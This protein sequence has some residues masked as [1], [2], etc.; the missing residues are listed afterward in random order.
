MLSSFLLLAQE[1]Q[2]ESSGGL[3]D[4][5]PGLMI[6]AIFVVW[7]MASTA[8]GARRIAREKSFEAG[9]LPDFLPE[10]AKVRGS[11]WTIAPQPADMLDRRVEITG[12]TDRKMII[13]ALNS[14][15]K[16]YMADFEDSN[17]PTWENV[18]DGQV[19]LRD[20]VNGTITFESA[21]GQL[22]TAGGQCLR[23]IRIHS[24]TTPQRTS[25]PV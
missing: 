6:A 11:E 5:V 10:T 21:A 16:V 17:A 7:S 3:I 20:A 14:G 2:D 8:F 12:P 24:R 15:A 1:S 22:A 4:V 18:I 25:R 23:P 13:N 9:T 19:N